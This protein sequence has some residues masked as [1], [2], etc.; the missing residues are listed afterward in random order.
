MTTTDCAPQSE[1]QTVLVVDDCPITAAAAAAL[2]EPHARVLVASSGE[3]ALS[4]LERGS[5]DVVLLDIGLQGIDGVE[6]LR[7][8][9]AEPRLAGTSVMLVTAAEPTEYEES[10]LALGASDFVRK[11]LRPGVVLRR[12]LNQLAIQRSRHELAEHNL[13]L[14]Q[15]IEA[16]RRA[17]TAVADMGLQAIS[18]LA[19]IRD[20]ET[21]NHL[22]R[23]QLYLRA[24]CADLRN[25][26]RW[27]PVITDGFVETLVKSA[28]MHDIG[29][30]G[31]PDHILLKPGPLTPSEW[32]VMRQHAALG[33]DA[34][35]RAR[36]GC[37]SPG[38]EYL[39]MACVIARHHHERWDGSGYPDALAGEDIPLPARLMAVADVYDALISR[40]PY[41][42]PM[43]AADA[44]QLVIQGSGT[45]FD[46]DLVAAFMRQRSEFEC[47]A[48][49]NADGPD[50][51]QLPCGANPF[52]P[53]SVL[54]RA[55]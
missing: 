9:R 27:A 12:V 55:A 44:A 32:T 22:I 14:S 35:E 21:G 29:K 36:R 43:D 24:L 11:P 41:K 1:L 47:I 7:R 17:G 37:N 28:P 15:E 10:G 16:Q 54:R 53:T 38:S 6:T 18:N 4:L 19:G 39:E 42:E 30:V 23:T 25:D 3:Q 52:A 50:E 40:R 31:I 2:L 13:R 5:V 51:V 48:A 33:A 45:H 26:P 20:P 8:I 49:R 46:P 34:L